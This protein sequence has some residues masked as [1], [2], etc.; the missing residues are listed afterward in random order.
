MAKMCL[1]D[2]RGFIEQIVEPGEE[3]EI[4]EGDDATIKWVLSASDDVTLDW[5]MKDGAF[6]ERTKHISYAIQRQVAYGPI[7]DQLDMFYKDQINGTTTF[8]DHVAA[9]KA[10]NP[11]PADEPDNTE[12]EPTGTEENPAWES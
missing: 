9:V 3:F 6:V 11:A 10:A 2:Y 7:G 5:I 12:I 4:Y 1:V 8:R